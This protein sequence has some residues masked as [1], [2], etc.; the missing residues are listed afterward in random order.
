MISTQLAPSM[1]TPYA[2]HRQGRFV[3][4][5]D[6]F[7]CDRNDLFGPD[8]APQTSTT[9]ARHGT[10][11]SAQRSPASW[12]PI[13]NCSPGGA[14]THASTL[15]RTMHSTVSSRSSIECDDAAEHV[16]VMTAGRSALQCPAAR[17]IDQTRAASCL[18]GTFAYGEEFYGN[19]NNRPCVHLWIAVN[20]VA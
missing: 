16:T 5:G 17:G 18:A 3:S 4:L 6:L 20:A 8:T 10:F 12:R 1:A 14:R 2:E 13:A 7:S 15:M 11:A 9:D 19:N